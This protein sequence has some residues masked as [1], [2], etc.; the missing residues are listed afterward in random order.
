MKVAR[1]CNG[2]VHIGEIHHVESE[3][4]F[5]R[6]SKRAVCDDALALAAQGYG[7]LG[8]TEAGGRPEGF[9]SPKAVIDLDQV[10]HQRGILLRTPGFD[11][12]LRK[13]RSASYRDRVCRSV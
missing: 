6:L 8:G 12:F 4:L 9:L 13:I 11:D 5:L 10:G 1:R 3:Q 7:L 2:G